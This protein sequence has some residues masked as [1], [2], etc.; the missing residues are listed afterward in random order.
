MNKREFGLGALSALLGA[1]AM[2]S[3]AVADSPLRYIVFNPETRETVLGRN[4][5]Q[6]RHMASLTKLMSMAL[7][8]E[9][10][11][12][13][14]TNFNLNSEVEIPNII[15]R[16]GRDIATFTV[17]AGQS[18]RAE[19]LMIGACSRSD[20]Y[21]TLAL[22]V[23]LGHDNV[24]GWDGSV[25]D[26]MFRFIQLMNEKAVEIGME[27]TNFEV[28]TGLPYRN[29]Y[30]TPYDMALLMDYLQRRFSNTVEIACGQDEFNIQPLSNAF[31]HTSRLLR[32]RPERVLWGKTGWT[33]AAGYC[34]GVM[35]ERDNKP[36]IS[37]VMGADGRGHRNSVTIDILT[38][39]YA[40][41]ENAPEPDDNGITSSPRPLA[42][43]APKIRPQPRPAQ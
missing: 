2:P 5:H 18:F 24:Y 16:I 17:S 22:A 19:D 25:A 26:K 4:I 40:A 6:R 8:F 43:R 33:N 11:A 29:H 7:V 39:A 27:N 3:K 32:A 20:A 23:H 30:S 35:Y 13:R 14:D 15:N 34:L 36:L 28:T 42:R 10:M 38:Q 1:S 12:D 31:E 21:S 41:L 9:A 37:V